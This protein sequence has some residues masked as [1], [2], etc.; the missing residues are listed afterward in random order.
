MPLYTKASLEALKEK[1]DLIE[2]VSSEV[3]LKRSG[4]SYKACCPFHEEKTPS[5]VVQKGDTHYHCFG[6]GAHGDAI[7][8]LMQHLKQS[9]T[10]AVEH[11]A[12]RFHIPLELVDAG[13]EKGTPKAFLRDALEN[14]S[15]F[16]HCYLLH[17]EEGRS[18]LQYLHQRGISL[19]FIRRFQVGLAPKEPKLMR[20]ILNTKKFSDQVLEEAGLLSQGREFFRDRITFPLR[21]PSGQVVGFSARKYK[22]E[23]LGGK[24]INSPETALFKKSK[25][26]F[27]M[28]ECRRQIAKKKC[29][30]LVEGQIDCLKMIESGFSV[31][32]AAL[33]TAFG[34]AHVDNLMQLGLQRVFI[35]FDGDVAGRA[36]ASKTGNLFQKVG[37][38]VTVVT[39]GEGLDPDTYLTR[40]GPAQLMEEIEKGVDYLTFQVDYVARE[41]QVDSPAGK[42]LLVN[43]LTAQIRDWEEPV[44]VHE[45]LRKLAHLAKVPE[46]I[47]G[48]GASYIAAPSIMRQALLASSMAVDPHRVLEL[49]LIR[50]LVL[51]GEEK[52]AWI[53]LAEGHLTADH[54]WVPV[55]KSL[56]GA[57]MEAVEKNT[58]RDLFSLFIA[59][60]REDADAC[61][62]EI[63]EKKIKREKADLL[64]VE[65]VQKLVD[66]QW[67][68]QG[69]EMRKEMQSGK[70]DE[71]QL[72]ELLKRFDSLKK[73]RPVIAVQS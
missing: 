8:F 64:F 7:Q 11:L 12:D 62:Q 22:E 3:P 31:T 15:L 4:S 53:Q 44:M 65:T 24:Y 69:E 72:L 5:F 47:V 1:I 26:L 10:E 45:S 50:W 19:A 58:P 33:G 37:A 32:V 39:L 56:Y 59:L 68:R 43:T 71:Q 35:L 9:F 16:F 61:M 18:A 17:T 14:A 66:R 29:A 48:V 60:E 6:C 27:G 52:P 25:H 67:L 42:T 40:F 73:N 36:A 2:V 13:E 34:Q 38:D 57:Y 20:N 30:I 63:L 23:T 54:F 55:C 41:L 46:E 70:Y 21:N 49:D 51:L 28:D